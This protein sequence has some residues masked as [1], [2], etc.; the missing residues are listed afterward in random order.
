[1]PALVPRDASS[2]EELRGTVP[3]GEVRDSVDVLPEGETVIRVT[4][5]K[6]TE[7][8]GGGFEPNFREA[9]RGAIVR[10]EAEPAAAGKLRG[11][12]Q[13]NLKERH[14][15]GEPCPGRSPVPHLSKR[16]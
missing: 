7:C 1:M 6:H 13:I 15:S 8:V 2:S 12:S 16:R 5:R 14:V 4:N 11:E 10:R 9:G 3:D